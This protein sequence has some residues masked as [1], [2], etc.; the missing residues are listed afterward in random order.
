MTFPISHIHTR[1]TAWSLAW[2]MSSIGR[3]VLTHVELEAAVHGFL[4][5]LKLERFSFYNGFLVGL[6]LA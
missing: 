5:Q 6:V 4:L 2:V 3:W 1:E